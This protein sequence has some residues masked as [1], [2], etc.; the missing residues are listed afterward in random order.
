VIFMNRLLPSTPAFQQIADFILDLASRCERDSRNR[1]L[2]EETGA[3]VIRPVS[4]WR[5]IAAEL[6]ESVDGLCEVYLTLDE[7][8]RERVRGLVQGHES[9]CRRLSGHVG[10]AAMRITTPEDIEWLRRGLAG[11]SIADCDGDYRDLLIAL[12]KLYLRAVQSRID[13]SHWF[14]EAGNMSSGVP[15]RLL[16]GKSTRDFLLGIEQTAYFQSTVANEV[17]RI[18]RQLGD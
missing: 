1:K 15:N 7:E 16:R 13:P 9:L 11:V 18:R 10:V 14:K 8:G 4:D 17:E 12:G 6:Q 3:E 5:K 2:D